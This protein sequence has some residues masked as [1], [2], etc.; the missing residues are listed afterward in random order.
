MFLRMVLQVHK[1]IYLGFC[2]LFFSLLSAGEFTAEQK[3]F[4]EENGYLGPLP[5][6]SQD[7]AGALGEEVD[8]LISVNSLPTSHRSGIAARSLKSSEDFQSDHLSPYGQPRYWAKC[9]HILIPKVA[10]IGRSEVFSPFI[11]DLL[12]PDILLWG[13]QFIKKPRGDAH[14]W[15]VDIEHMAWEGVTFWFPLCNVSKEST[16]KF[17]PGSHHFDLI[18]QFLPKKVNLENDQAVLDAIHPK[19]PD[20]KIVSMDI[21]PGEFVLFAGRTW[22]ST[23]NQTKY[24]RKALIFQYCRTDA[25]VRIPMSFNIPTIWAPDQPWVMLIS[26]EDRYGIN[27]IYPC[28]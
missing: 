21:K 27:H 26:G 3:A 2:C 28:E 10:A 6:L 12:G 22:H 11:R 17:I 7:E 18:P 24:T 25:R 13:A 1:K 4:F 15:H 14:R 5:F 20:A 16:I 23:I 8:F 19:Y 9:A